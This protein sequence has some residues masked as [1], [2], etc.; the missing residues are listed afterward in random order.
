M[1]KERKWAC[2]GKRGRTLCASSAANR[3]QSKVGRQD[4][5]Y[6]NARS[7]CSRGAQA[8]TTSCLRSANLGAETALVF[9][10]KKPS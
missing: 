5:L 2:F 1:V 3:G 7:S 4:R 9:T 8:L 10:A 6:T